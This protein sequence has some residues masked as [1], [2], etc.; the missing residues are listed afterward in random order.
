MKRKYKQKF[1]FYIATNNFTQV[2]TSLDSDPQTIRSILKN[3]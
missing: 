3:L 2:N 1:T